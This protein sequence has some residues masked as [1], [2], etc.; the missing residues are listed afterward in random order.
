MLG[1]P[2]SA[3][4]A[5]LSGFVA[6]PAGRPVVIGGE[7]GVEAQGPK[8]LIHQP[9]RGELERAQ[10]LRRNI[11]RLACGR[12]TTMQAPALSYHI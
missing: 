12:F 6:S 8:L 10:V 5:L 2:V 7:V 9:I 1:I 11:P 3:S 4:S